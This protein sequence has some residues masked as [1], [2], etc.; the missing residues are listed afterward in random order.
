MSQEF[1][2]YSLFIVQVQDLDW[3]KQWLI[4]TVIDFYGA[5]ICLSVIT[6]YSEPFPNGILWSIGFC[7]LGSPICCLYCA[8]RC[9]LITLKGFPKISELC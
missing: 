7:L 9:V 2:I 5:A 1:V 6:I 3:T 8:Y 4:T